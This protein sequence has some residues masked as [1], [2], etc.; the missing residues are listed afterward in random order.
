MQKDVQPAS[1]GDLVDA[2][3]AIAVLQTELAAVKSQLDQVS[4]A[5]NEVRELLSEAKGGWR[6]MMALGGAAAVVGGGISWAIQHLQV[7]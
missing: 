6:L 7:R 5:L 3:I 2:K 1:H 4:E